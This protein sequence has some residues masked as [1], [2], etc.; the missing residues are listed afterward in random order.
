[1]ARTEFLIRRHPRTATAAVA[2][3]LLGSAVTAIAVAPIDK[4][5]TPTPSQQLITQTLAPSQLQAQVSA[6]ELGELT[7][8]RNDLTRRGDTADSL[9][10]RL[11]ADDAKASAFLRKHLV[12]RRILDGQSGKLVQIELKTTPAGRQVENL[13][14]KGPAADKTLRETHFERITVERVG[15]DFIAHAETLPMVTEVRMSSGRIATS[16]FAAADDIGLPDEVTSQ[17]GEIFDNDIDIRKD[18]RRGDTFAVVYEGLT[19]DGD[20]APWASGTG[21]VLAV[22]LINKGKSHEAIWY[23]DPSARNGGIYYN[24]EGRTKQ[25]ALLASPMPFSR[26]TSDF[27][28][29]F[30]PLKHEWRAHNGID[31]GAPTGTPV[32]AVGQ[33]LVKFAGVQNGYGNVVILQHPKDRETRYAHLSRIDV[34]VGDKVTQGDIV[35]AVGSTGWATGPHLHFEFKVKGDF[36]DPAEVARVSDNIEL[37]GAERAEFKHRTATVLDQLNTI[38]VRQPGQ[39]LASKK[40]GTPGKTTM[41]SAR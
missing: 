35:G 21:R 27:G 11:G 24:A 14:V 36:I 28:M 32:R 1:M 37:N 7:L 38:D 33:A 23:Q 30:H 17:I 15:E 8:N 25:R 19:A 10:R 6:L 29:R 22:R 18:L 13:V 20:A 26:V 2:A 4:I 12:A 34:R 3:T 5:E 39:A 31:F 41:A 16:L 9:L 40:G